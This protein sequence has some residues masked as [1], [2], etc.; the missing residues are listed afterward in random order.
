M[1]R[2][3]GQ[4]LH[5]IEHFGGNQGYSTTILIVSPFSL[6]ISIS[7]GHYEV[8]SISINTQEKPKRF[9]SSVTL[10]AY[11]GLPMPLATKLRPVGVQK[12]IGKWRNLTQTGTEVR[13][14]LRTYIPGCHLR[15][16]NG[17]FATCHSLF[18]R[19][20]SQVASS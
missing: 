18:S 7:L 1:H 16:I 14:N 13:D 10:S 12:S 15:R 20:C 5:K 11:K 17:L 9:C 3:H 6:Q 2:K 4:T 8:I 19:I